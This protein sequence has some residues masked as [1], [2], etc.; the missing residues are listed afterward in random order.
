M[1]ILHKIEVKIG[2]LKEVGTKLD[3]FKEKC[4][5]EQNMLEGAIRECTTISNH[6]AKLHAFVDK[7]LEKG[8]ITGAMQ[9]LQIASYVKRYISRAVETVST[10]S[11]TLK[12][13]Q[14]QQASE[15]K[16]FTKSIEF[17]KKLFEQEH[18]KINNI[19]EAVSK[20]DAVIDSIGDVKQTLKDEQGNV[21]NL[22]GRSRRPVGVHPGKS[23]K[24]RRL[25]KQ[26]RKELEEKTSEELEAE[27]LKE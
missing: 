8:V 24:A 1:S 2:C 21:I 3:D 15:E 5:K 22:K 13:K 25:E 10:Y 26:M 11:E 9:P 7:D 23:I 16:A 14:I 20:G 4:E 18:T 12:T 17:V 19:Q 27:L 6:I